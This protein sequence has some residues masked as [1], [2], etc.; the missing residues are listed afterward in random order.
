MELQRT[1]SI[2]HHERPAALAGGLALSATEW[3]VGDSETISR[4]NQIIVPTRRRFNGPATILGE[5]ERPGL[6]GPGSSVLPVSD[7]NCRIYA[8]C[9]NSWNQTGTR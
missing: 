1:P 4:R 7:R 3:I 8:A 9:G 2:C 5:T 6:I